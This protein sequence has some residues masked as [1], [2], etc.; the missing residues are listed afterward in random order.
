MTQH[1]SSVIVEPTE[2]PSASVIWLHGLG[3]NGHDFEA[4]LPELNLPPEVAIRFIFPH[5]PSIPVTINGGMVMPAW[6]D[7]LEMGAGR[8]LNTEQLLDSAQAIS[9]LVDHEIAS[10][11]RSDRII[12]AGFSQGG[13]VA[14]HVAL[15]YPEPLAGL[16]A[17][18]TY[19]PTAD[20]IEVSTAN[21][22]LD[23]EVMH[24]SYDPVVLPAMG[25][26][27]VEAL[28]QKGFM[29]NWREYPM[30]HQVCYPQI[31]DIS[32]WLQAKLL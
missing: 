16:L 17:L 31:K 27:A 21:K 5:S 9:K 28:K 23:I 18:S 11:I 26:E 7:I 19:F 2:T 22:Q 15:T 12:L 3:A 10:G 4:I 24:G 6:Y 8:K 32:K 14:Y 25:K 20:D 29:P 13:A 30:E 1:L